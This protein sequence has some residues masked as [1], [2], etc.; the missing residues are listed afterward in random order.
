[1]PVKENS[2]IGDH[3]DTRYSQSTYPEESRCLRQ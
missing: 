1:V 2:P 3:L